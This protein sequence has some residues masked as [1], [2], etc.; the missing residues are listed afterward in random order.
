MIDLI[1]RVF[2]NVM[3]SVMPS[4]ASLLLFRHAVFFAAIISAG[5]RCRWHTGKDVTWWEGSLDFSGVD[6]RF[7][8][9]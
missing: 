3:I 4:N 7:V 8:L 2:V 5:K 6:M 9:A 1:A